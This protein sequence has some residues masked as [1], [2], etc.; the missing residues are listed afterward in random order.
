MV[1]EVDKSLIL[2]GLRLMIRIRSFEESVQK[3]FTQ[4]KL[5]GFVHLCIG[6]EAVAAGVCLAIE[7]TDQITSNHRGHGHVI[8]KGGDVKRMFA[9]LLG[10]SDG[11]CGGKGGS[12]HIVDFASGMLGTNGIVGAGIPIATGAAFANKYLKSDRVAVS[13]FGDGATNQGV[14]FEAMNMSALWKLPIIFIVENNQYTEWSRTGD[15]SVGT[16][17]SR[18]L[19]F[20]IRA[21]SIDGNDFVVVRQMVGEA[22]KRAR[23]GGGPEVIECMTY[24]WHGHNEGEEAF[25]GFYRPKEEIDAWKKRDPIEALIVRLIA[26]KTISPE[27]VE[28]MRSEEKSLVDRAYEF[29][30]A[31]KPSD[32]S[33]ALTD[34]FVEQ[35]GVK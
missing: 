34:V 32:E 25:A 8:A 15:L 2:K 26:E 9:E 18:A 30:V 20:G 29:A 16:T 27:E 5:P 13:F 6:Q 31:S 1:G 17:V 4:G 3:L 7:S 11:Y 14:F 24:R 19:P 28:K 22:V 12:M 23:A 21:S 35:G 33:E 10:K